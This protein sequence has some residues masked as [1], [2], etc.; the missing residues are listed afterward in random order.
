[1]SSTKEI[2]NMDRDRVALITGGG[3]GIGKEIA[4]KLAES[5]INIAIVYSKSSREASNTVAEIHQLGVK[6]KAYKC[7]VGDD[8]AVRELVKDVVIEFGRI[9]YLVNAAGKTYYI[10]HNDLEGMEGKYFDDI[11]NVN[12]KGTFFVSRAA[13]EQIIKNKGVIINIASTSGVLFGGSCIAY[14]ASKAAIINM[15]KSLARVF[16][17]D[18]RV[19]CISPG[20]VDTRWINKET[21]NYDKI[22]QDTP[23]KRIC[24]PQDIAE[25]AKCLIQNM[26]FI[27]GTNIVV[28]GGRLMI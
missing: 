19:V 6:A 17:P 15:T 21:W 13:H 2:D 8:V 26:T 18:A 23:L 27:T 12:V 4:I 14:A 9:D 3:T 28:D 16:A 5:G 20:L 1:M 7:D 24:S 22:I 10:S 11:F 25:V